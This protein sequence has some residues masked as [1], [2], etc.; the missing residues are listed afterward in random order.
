MVD[1]VIQ[2]C[3]TGMYLVCHGWLRQL[4]IAFAGCCPASLEYVIR[5]AGYAHSV[6]HKLTGQT[7]VKTVNIHVHPEIPAF[8]A[9]HLRVET[10]KHLSAFHRITLLLTPPQ[11]SCLL[12]LYCP[13]S[14]TS[15]QDRRPPSH[16]AKL[17]GETKLLRCAGPACAVQTG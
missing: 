3:L 12:T 1:G 16:L 8:L 2:W 14:K 4:T 17:K 5:R 6:L 15:P 7:R 9:S 11:I 10:S 13:P